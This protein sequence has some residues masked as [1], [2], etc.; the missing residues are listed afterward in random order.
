[1]ANQTEP[2]IVTYLYDKAAKEKRPVGGTFEL[3]PF[4]NMD[5]QMCYIKMTQKEQEQ[6]GRLL[7]NEEWLNLAEQMKKEGVLFL[8]LTG[9]EPFLKKDFRELYEKLHKMGFMISINSNGTMI[10]DETVDWLKK[11]PPTRINISLYGATNETYKRLCKHSTG[12]DKVTYA[13]DKLRAAAIEVKL[14]CSLTPYN[15]HDIEKMIKFANERDLILEVATYM[16]P[17]I[18]KGEWG[19]NKSRFTPSECGYYAAKVGCLQKSMDAF[20]EYMK[21]DPFKKVETEE[22]LEGSKVLCRGGTSSFWISWNGVMTGCGLM[23]RPSAKPFEVGFVNAWNSIREETEKI[24]LPIE[25]ANC[26][27]K[28]RCGICAASVLAENGNFHQK[29][30]YLCEM[31]NSYEKHCELIYSEMRVENEE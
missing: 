25:C 27:Q 6:K 1:M 22:V 18:R 11:C 5:C 17:P 10:D 12:F 13:I 7:T 15:C 24:R 26:C 20:C 8:L 3:I 14:S 4:C 9:G 28:E 21:T 31:C 29:P 2:R 30:E 16:F 19:D 23:D